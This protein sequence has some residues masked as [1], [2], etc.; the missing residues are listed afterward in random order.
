MKEAAAQPE[1]QRE[2][3][4][5]LPADQP[6]RSNSLE[7]APPPIRVAPAS[8]PVPVP[9][10]ATKSVATTQPL[11]EAPVVA[12]PETQPPAET[13]AVDASPAPAPPDA[14]PKAGDSTLDAKAPIGL[15][16]I[17]PY[18]ASREA[19]RKW[20]LDQLTADQ[21]L[22]L[23][24]ELNRMVMQSQLTRR[25]QNEDMERRLM[26]AAEPILKNCE[27]KDVRYRFNILDSD[28]V[29]A[30]SHPGGYVYVTRGLM[31]W[32]SEDQDYVLQF[33]LAHEIHHVD[34]GDA[35][36]CLRTPALKDLPYGTGELF[37]M[38]IF[39]RSYGETLEFEADDWALQQ[40]KRLYSTRRECLAFLTNFDR[41]A[42][43]NG[44]LSGDVRPEDEPD[45]PLFELHYRALPSA[46]E[47]LKRLK[48]KLPAQAAE[49]AG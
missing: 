30:F 49:K 20:D 22:E 17:N 2:G 44:F 23:G 34:R 43:A 27:R 46:A 4:A 25:F 48:D 31:N 35:I 45:T 6:D 14:A 47:R 1:P 39:P 38:F 32:A 28:A 24:R 29:N 41:Y 3:S 13:K 15:E 42:G 19:K 33:A 16:S 21:E 10:L 12:T 5:A 37:L 36:R 18:F 40:L 8:E 26:E 11:A 7:P 9:D